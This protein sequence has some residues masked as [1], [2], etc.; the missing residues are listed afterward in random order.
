MYKYLI[1]VETVYIE[2]ELQNCKVSKI[3]KLRLWD[4]FKKDDSSCS[5]STVTGTE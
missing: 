2:S 3:V 1:Y 4:N 5:W